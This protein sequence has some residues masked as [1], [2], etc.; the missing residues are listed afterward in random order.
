[1]KKS[2]VLS[3]NQNQGTKEIKAFSPKKPSQ[4]E[5]IIQYIKQH[6]AIITLQFCNAVNSQRILDLLCGA[7]CAL[8]LKICPLDKENY[9]ITK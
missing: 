7:V 8:N 4:A 6:P 3:N 1:M 5:E 9:L 2:T